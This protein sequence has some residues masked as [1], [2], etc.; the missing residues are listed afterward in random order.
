[1]SKD[2]VSKIDMNVDAQEPFEEAQREILGADHAYPMIAFGTLKKKAAFKLYARAKGLDF[3]TANKISA[4]ISQYEEA[5]KYADDDEKDS[6]N[7]YDFVDPQYHDYITKSKAYWGVINSKSKAPCAYLLYQGSIRREIGLIKCKSETSKK[8]YITTVIDGAVAENYKFLKND[9][10]I[11]DTVRLTDAIFKRIGIKHL[12]VNELLQSVRND[13]SVWSLYANGY[14]IGVNQCEKPNAIKRLKRYQPRNVS[15]LSAF[16]A[17]IRP[18]FKSMYSR[19]ESREPF[20]YGIPVLDNAIQT[21]QFP[22][23]YILY[24]ENLMSVLNLAGFPMDECYSIIKAI[25]KKHPEKVLPLKEKFI[26]GMSNKIKGQCAP[27]QTEQQV[28]EQIWQIISDA[29]AYGFNSAHAYCMALDSLYNAWQKAHYPYEF[30]EVLMQRFSDKG[31]KDKVKALKLEM[32]QAFGIEVG[33]ME[34]GTDNRSFRADPKNHCI[35]PSLLSIKGLSKTCANELY[36]LSQ[37]RQYDSFIDL[38]YDIKSKTRVNSGQME[39]LIKLNY[40]RKFGNPNQLLKQAALFDRYQECKQLQKEELD[41]LLPR[42]TILTLCTKETA[43]LYTGI[44]SRQLLQYLCKSTQDIKTPVPDILQYEQECLGYIQYTDPSLDFSYCY[45]QSVDGKYKNK[46]LTLYCLA[47]GTISEYKVKGS[48][49][50]KDPVSAGEILRILATANE[51]KWSKTPS[52]DWVQK[53]ETEP[54]LKKYT[55]VRQRG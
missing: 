38:L 11:V 5:L 15:E 33:P 50:E 7:I 40:F 54:V 26:T 49:L 4:Q 27:G 2:R 24:Q 48:Q 55:H 46:M 37:S 41:S 6:I 39:T 1:M 43:K 9:W 35:N 17:A 10:L 30:Y 13:D 36:C 19:F 47:D 45:V 25:A 51:P 14:T 44:H 18:G 53:Q 3:E 22:Y 23:S 20:S 32:K 42:E 8:E 29:T 21:E 12:T 16:V 31:N 52:G 34:F 28:A